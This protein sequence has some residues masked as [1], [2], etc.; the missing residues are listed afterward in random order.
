MLFTKEMIDNAVG[1]NDE[2]IKKAVERAK[3]GKD[4]IILVNTS[5]VGYCLEEINHQIIWSRHHGNIN[6]IGWPDDPENSQ[7]RPAMYCATYNSL[8][9]SEKRARDKLSG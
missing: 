7:F 5:D 1:T 8:T 3:E 4:T 2:N 9:A 6:V